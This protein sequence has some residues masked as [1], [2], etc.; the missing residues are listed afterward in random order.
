VAR[1]ALRESDLP[2]ARLDG[3]SREIRLLV[4]HRE[5]L[6]R[7]RTR[8]QSRLRWHLHELEPGRRIPVKAL[9]R[10][11]TMDE[12]GALLDGHQGPVARVPGSW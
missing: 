11:K 10:F 1:A 9:N 7:E 5:D 8:I 4:D 3:P 2:L 12:L 6:V